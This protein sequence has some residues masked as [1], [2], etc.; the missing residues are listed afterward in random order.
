MDKKG[1]WHWT[2]TIQLQKQDSENELL[3][4][5]EYSICGKLI[6]PQAAV[7]VIRLYLEFESLA[8]LQTND[9]SVQENHSVASP[10]FPR[11]GALTPKV[12]GGTNLLFDQLLRKTA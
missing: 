12:L 6:S 7:S 9:K 11:Q 10:R 4:M 3:E 8:N 5:I 1:Q 2:F